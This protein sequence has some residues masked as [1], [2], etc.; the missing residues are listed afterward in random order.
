MSKEMKDLLTRWFEEVWNQKRV[1]TIEE[2]F[3]ADAILHDGNNT[4]RGTEEFRRFHDDL[5]SA[6]DEIHIT[7]MDT[8]ADGELASIRWRAEV[9]EKKSG[10]RAQFTGM[11][12]VKFKDGRFHEAWQNWDL[13]AM[14]QQL[15]GAESTGEIAKAAG[16]N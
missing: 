2:L 12:M 3:P 5:R 16:G 9:R 1:E 13:H 7:T 8:V 4:I 10:K 6:F 14:T 15:L 11:S